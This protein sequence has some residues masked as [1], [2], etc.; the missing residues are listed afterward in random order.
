MG[1][2]AAELG[3]AGE[4]DREAYAAV[5]AGKHPVTGAVLVS[6]PE[7]RKFVDA[8]G[9][10]RRLDPILGYDIRFAAPKSVSLLYAVGSPEV[11]AAIL[12]AHDHA[13]AEAVGYLERTACFVQR[14]KGGVVIEPGAGFLSMS[15]RHRSSRAGDPALHTHLVTANMTRATSDGR[16]LSL[17]N[18]RRQSPLLREA[19]AAGHVYQAAL[20]AELTRG[21]GAE[22]QAVV[23]GYA[24]LAGIGRPVIDHFSQRRAEIVAAMAERGISSP[25]AAEVAAYRTRDAKDYAV[26]PDTQRAEWISRAAEFDLTPESIDRMLARGRRREPRPIGA[27]QLDRALADLEAHHSHFDRRDLLSAVANQLREGSDAG[28]LEA[29]VASLLDGPQLIEVHHGAGPLD[30]TY[31]TT[32]RLW[33]TEQSFMAMARKGEDAGAAVV[34]GA[35]LT[36]VLDRHRY[37][38]DQQVEMVRRLTT[39][40]ERIVAVASLPGTGKTTALAAS[41]EAWA[42]AGIRGVGVAAARSASGELSDAGVPATSVTAFLIQTGELAERGIAPL[43]PGTVIIVDESSTTPTPHMAALA[44]LAEVCDGKLVLI[45]DPRQIGAVG[46]GGLYGNLTNEIEPVVFDAGSSPARFGGP[47]NRRTGP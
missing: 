37:L 25:A 43:P 42:A 9:R 11:R 27:E 20:R 44:D 5:L 7:P 39:G 6:R 41:Q 28:G 30:P 3:L 26:D 4:V 22:W 10:E 19:K 12:R 21:V 34:D 8:D 16:W 32:P 15:F 38:S 36:A 18:P 47:R 1:E 31:Y 13:V 45:G 33:Q 35:T 46:P 2:L 24:D 23:N 17:A 14:G 29:A 40:G